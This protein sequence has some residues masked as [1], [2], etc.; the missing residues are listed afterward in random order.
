MATSCGPCATPQFLTD[1]FDL[2]VVESDEFAGQRWT[3]LAPPS[4][5]RTQSVKLVLATPT[6]YTRSQ[7]LIALRPRYLHLGCQNLTLNLPDVVRHPFLVIIFTSKQTAARMF[8]SVTFQLSQKLC[9]GIPRR[10][11]MPISFGLCS[12]ATI[13]MLQMYLKILEW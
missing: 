6:I 11:E 1:L 5:S 9:P 7:S 4:L 2:A 8:E 13:G 3:P 10:A 12:D